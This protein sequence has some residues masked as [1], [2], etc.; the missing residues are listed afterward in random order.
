[1]LKESSCTINIRIFIDLSFLEQKHK[2]LEQQK[3]KQ[4]K[5]QQE[6]KHQR[7]FNGCQR[8]WY[9]IFFL[10]GEWIFPLFS[11]AFVF[12]LLCYILFISFIPNKIK[13]KTTTVLLL[14]K[15]PVCTPSITFST[16]QSF[17]LFLIGNSTKT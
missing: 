7:N 9:Y 4:Q 8:F 14:L 10:F 11:V 3:L 15:H 16:K 12:T 5:A 6:N 1:M 2:I 13:K 17:C